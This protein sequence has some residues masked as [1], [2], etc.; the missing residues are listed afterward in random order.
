MIILLVMIGG[1]I[2]A[3]LRALLSNLINRS[4]KTNFPVATLVVNLLGCFSFGL[5]SP[6]TSSESAHFHL[7]MIGILGGFTTFSTLQLELSTQVRR[8]KW[9]QVWLILMFQYIGGF[10]SLIAGY[11]LSYCV[12]S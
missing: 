10:L 4:T 7:L 12:I 6:L 5:V 2:G 3:M 11:A 8:Q 1:G 9:F